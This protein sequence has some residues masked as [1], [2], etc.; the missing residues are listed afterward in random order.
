MKKKY[1][2][3][4]EVLGSLLLGAILIA[5]IL[6]YAPVLAQLSNYNPQGLKATTLEEV[7]VLP[8]EEIDLATT[9]L[10]L[11]KEWDPNFDVTGSLEEIDRMALELD[12]RI[13]PQDSPERIVSVMNRYLFAENAY[14]ASDSADPYYMEVL[15]NSALP[16]IIDNKEGNCLG[17]SLLYLALAER[18]GL[19]FHGVAAPKHMFVRYDDGKKRINIETTDKGEKYEDSYY[20]KLFMLHSTYRNHGFYLKNL[21]KREVVEGFLHTL[22]VAYGTR[23]MHNKAIA[24]FRKAIEINPDYAE[25]HYNLGVAYSMKGM[26][27]EEV[28]EYRKAIELHPNYADPHYNLGTVY[29]NK[30]MFDQAI[31]EYKKAIEINPNLA[32]AHN[33]LAVAYY[34]K[35]EY[36]L[37]IEH[38]DKVIELGYK[39]HPQFLEDL[40]PY[41]EK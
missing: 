13:S 10:I 20:E 30:G 23:G 14:S 4:V 12:V 33:N 34:L 31:A 2:A 1:K 39:V 9:I 8:D 5:A 6:A 38:C 24:K 16:R 7:L 26:H 27:D 18:L 35:G 37:A 25:A 3:K 36:G 19:P 29:L 22:G 15:E 17:L 32:E 28:A 11:Y 41:R 40:K 21:R